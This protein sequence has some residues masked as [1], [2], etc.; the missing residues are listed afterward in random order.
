MRPATRPAGYRQVRAIRVDVESRKDIEKVKN[1]KFQKLKFFDPL[2]PHGHSE[3]AI[4]T[5]FITLTQ[6][7][8]ILL[9]R[10]PG[11]SKKELKIDPQADRGFGAEPQTVQGQSG[12]SFSQLRTSWDTII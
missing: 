1:K 9:Q 6:P 3:I 2:E 12:V 7:L 4:F 8:Q 5:V 10:S 11:G